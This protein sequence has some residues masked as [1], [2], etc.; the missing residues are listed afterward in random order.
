[1]GA[2]QNR[3]RARASEGGVAKAC[4][5]T[6][7]TVR[8][9]IR[10]YVR[11]LGGTL[12]VHLHCR[13]CF[14]LKDGA[15][16]PEA[17]AHRAAELGMPAVALT[18][19]D[20]LTGAVRFTDACHAAGVKPILGA[21]L[22]LGAGRDGAVILLARDA[23]G[24]ANLSPADHRGAHG[25]SATERPRERGE[26]WLSPRAVM[27]RAEGLVV[28]PR[29]RV[30][31]RRAG[32]RRPSRRGQ[33]AG[34]ALARGVRR[35]VL[36][37]GP[38]PPR[39]GARP[40][41]PRLAAAGRRGRSSRV[42]AT[43]AVRY[44]VP[45]DAFLADALE[46][47]REIVPIAEHHVT[48]A[49]RRGLAEAGRAR[50]ARCSPSGPTS[51]T[52]P[53]GS[54]SACTFDLGLGAGP[55]PGLPDAARPQRRR[56]AGR[57]VLARRRAIAGCA[58][59]AGAPRPAAPRARSMIRR[60]GYAAYFL[61]V[62]DIAADVKAMGIRAACRGS[63]AGSL[64][65]Y[66]TG[67]SDVDPCATTSSFERFMNPHARRAARHR[68]R[69]GVGPPRGRLRHDPVAAT[70]RSARACVAMVD[71][72]RARA[73]IREVGK[74]LGLPDDEVDTVAKAFPH[75]SATAPA[76][77]PRAACRS[78]TGSTWRRPAR[79]A[80]PGGR[81]ARTASPGTSRCTRAG[82]V[83]SSHDLRRPRSAGA[84]RH[85][86]RMVQADKDDVELPRAT[87]SSTSW[88][89]GC[90]RRCATPS[91]RSRAPPARRWTSTRIPL[92]DRARSS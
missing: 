38:A 50:C 48:R 39:A 26:P 46:C 60:M 11:V 73:A 21:R 85:D 42:V 65:C 76:R 15:F 25:R 16:T 91:T 82:I 8:G 35:M 36:R 2:G 13:S 89:C 67:I 10:T 37:R 27:A 49:Q 79:A 57:A 19:A 28:P 78:C 58:R 83:L 56:A 71:T 30:T 5:C 33:G 51:A 55:L 3:R 44:L 17:L 4:P 74:A 62:A 18:D 75:I 90:S 40:R 59:T 87:S 34:P 9:T 53:S 6:T 72:Y 29:S 77:G 12:F 66:L 20:N 86:H 43:N 68:H 31:A 84:L 64:V 23:R 80:V 88:G 1:M 7:W 70:A 61:T 54:P 81:A 47:M 52:R 92:D 63:A 45:E 69:R 41:D 32:H 14:S 22:T 24:Y